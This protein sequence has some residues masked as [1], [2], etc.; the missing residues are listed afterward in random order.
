MTAT[1]ENEPSQ[2]YL[3][4]PGLSRAGLR[5]TT[6]MIPPPPNSLRHGAQRAQEPVA[7]IPPLSPRQREARIKSCL[8]ATA[9]A[10]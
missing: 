10:A 7:W 4:P 8:L 5:D 6:A 1:E 3:N 2:P 9:A